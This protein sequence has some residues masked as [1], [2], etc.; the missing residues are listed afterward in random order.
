MSKPRVQA[1]RKRQ[2]RTPD[3]RRR[4]TIYAVALG[5]AIAV[6]ATVGVLV[7]VTGEDAP[8]PRSSTLPESYADASPELIEA[9]QEVGFY[10]KTSPGVGQIQDQPASA[11]Q[12]PSNPNLLPVGSEAPAF[13]LE[14][15]TG[16]SVS[17]SDFRGKATLIE[18]FATW[19][20][21]CA[22]QAPHL[23][24]LANELRGPK[25]AFVSVNANGE[26]AASVFAY[27]V[28]YG[29]PFPALLD[30]GEVEGSFNSPGSPGPVSTEYQVAS[31]PTFYV[32]DPEGKITWRSDG[33]QPTALLR[34]ELER[35]A[36]GGA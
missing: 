28:F 7:A 15:P 34:Q 18:F 23:V 14:T 10:P 30:P 4:R 17:L 27:E 13:T 16:N 22:A 31:Y 20:P 8:P 11:A 21:H 9:A 29:L 35:A 1:P 36:A 33:E 32:V 24:E 12:P 5:L 3:G 25:Y 19:C 26:D 6:T 2:S